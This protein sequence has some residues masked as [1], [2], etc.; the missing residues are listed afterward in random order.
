MIELS[1]A[2]E[3]KSITI[4]QW[5]KVAKLNKSSFYEWKEKLYKQIK[6]KEIY[7]IEKI[8]D[9]VKESKGRYG[10][11]RVSKVLRLEYGLIVNHKKVLRIMKE[12]E[13]LC[14]KFKNRV[15]KY[16][17]YKGTVGKIA[18]NIVN[19]NFKAD[20]PNKLWLTDITE[21]KIRNSEKK[22]YLSPILDTFNGEIISYSIGFSPTVTLTNKSLE[23]A[24][25]RIKNKEDLTIHTDQGF[26]YQHSSFVRILE[27]NNIR[28]SMSRK[29]NCL[30][31][32]PMENFFGILKQEMFY[33]ENY[34]SYEKL[35]EDI[36]EYIKW[37]NTKRIKEN[38]K[39]MSP[40]DYR[41]HSFE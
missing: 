6:S 23:K 11:R 22:I 20:K 37:Y 3:Y 18:N 7:I 41:L 25:K 33:G 9:I 19:R 1:K 38:L 21:F 30:D 8:K 32:A 10:Y 13:L 2:K 26:H 17:S 40:I 14:I 36:K 39:G 35:I 28:Q 31:N 24:L 5:L 12:N 27:N 29:G 16:N 34:S 4:L 15:R